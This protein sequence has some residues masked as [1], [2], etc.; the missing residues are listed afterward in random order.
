ML[1]EDA[2]SSPSASEEEEEL[3]GSADGMSEIEEEV[4]DAIAAGGVASVAASDVPQSSSRKGRTP[5]QR[6][7]R[8]KRGP[9]VR[10]VESK[11]CELC[12]LPGECLLFGT[13]LVFIMKIMRW[14]VHGTHEC[15][16]SY[17]TVRSLAPSHTIAAPTAQ[18]HSDNT[19]G[20]K[21]HGT[22]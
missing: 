17:P 19:D 20:E 22:Q 18:S 16:Y 21:Q 4:E 15:L 1:A 10:N 5:K 9:V 14:S 2:A 12:K 13:P 3:G 7:S 8:K 11:S 6:R